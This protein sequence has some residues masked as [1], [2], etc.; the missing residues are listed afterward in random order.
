MRATCDE[1]DAFDMDMA[2][3][4]LVAIVV[5]LIIALVWGLSRL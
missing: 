4:V 3:I 2:L 5:V 1:K